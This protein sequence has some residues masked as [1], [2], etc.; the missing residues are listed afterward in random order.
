MHRDCP[1]SNLL[2]R[3]VRANLVSSSS[4][5][6]AQLWIC[7]DKTC[8]CRIDL[9]P[10]ICD[11]AK[12]KRPRIL[13]PSLLLSL[14][15]FRIALISWATSNRRSSVFEKW[16]VSNLTSERSI[17][18]PGA[19]K[20]PENSVSLSIDVAHPS[21]LKKVLTT[22]SQCLLK[23]LSSKTTKSSKYTVHSR[24]SSLTPMVQRP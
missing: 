5:V 6:E 1:C 3:K 17:K 20:L 13:W 4:R 23:V 15:A 10:W 21:I 12:S 2:Q 11:S 19:F 22:N 9:L 16:I 8:I 14:P 7:L 18:I 24:E